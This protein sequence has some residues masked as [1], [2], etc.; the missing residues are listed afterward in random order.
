VK[1]VRWVLVVAIVSLIG[2]GGL[3][4]ASRPPRGAPIQLLPP[5]SPV[6][7]IIHVSGA[8]NHPGVYTLNPGCRVQEAILAA[9]GF[10]QDA[11]SQ[12]INLAATLQDG[13]QLWIPSTLDSQTD[14]EGSAAETI[15][16]TRLSVI[17]LVD[18]NTANQAELE[19]LP[20]IGPVLA[21][22][23]IAYRETE[24]DFIT[25]EDLQK[26]PGIG[27]ATFEK[28]QAWITVNEEPGS[29]PP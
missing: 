6:P 4:I 16:A 21:A 25:I 26:V 20:G 2:V 12:T 5:P 18:I 8:V 10:R 22:D 11:I 9:G 29:V 13:S 15:G 1:A 14:A 24:G 3:W 7:I 27:P 19:T 17:D 23:I 28:I